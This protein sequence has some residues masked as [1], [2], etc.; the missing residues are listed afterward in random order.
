VANPIAAEIVFVGG[1]HLLFILRVIVAR[2][3][4]ARQRT[5]DLARFQEL[6]PGP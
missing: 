2:A 1:A 5:V 3:A 6:K 4:A